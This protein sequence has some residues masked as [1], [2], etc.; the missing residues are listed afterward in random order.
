MT[1]S[2]GCGG[3]YYWEINNIPEWTVLISELPKALE[4][5]V[6]EGRILFVSRN[7]EK[8]NYMNENSLK[9]FERLF[10]EL[11]A[12]LPKCDPGYDPLPLTQWILLGAITEVSLQIILAVYHTDFLNERWQLWED[13]ET[14]SIRNQID[15]L[16]KKAVAEG[17]ISAKQRKTIVGAID[18]EIKKHTKHH[19][20]DRI[21]LDEL[22]QLAQKTGFLLSSDILSQLR[23]IQ[24]NRNCIHAF[25]E[26]SIDSWNELKVSLNTLGYM[27]DDF[28][29]RF[30]AENTLLSN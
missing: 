7:G 15:E 4:Y 14:A 13:T 8:L 23:I 25:S 9:R 20:I 24:R 27:W 19:E 12:S 2:C 10:V 11:A 18:D 1:M 30:E 17:K 21:M 6:K 3:K 28:G 5:F 16:L 22:I 26:R 29:Y